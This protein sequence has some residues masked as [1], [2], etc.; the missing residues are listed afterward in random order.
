MKKLII[1][2]VVLCALLLS[3]SCNSVPTTTQST[4]TITTTHEEPATT[5]IQPTPQPVGKLRVHF[6]DVGQGDAILVDYGDTEIL[7]D[8]GD[9]SPGVVTYLS[10]FVDGAIEVMVATHPHADHIGG[11]IAVLEQYEVEV[12]IPAEIRQCDRAK[13]TP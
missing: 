6:I 7:I 4:Q 10:D 9:R 12:N 11:L 1:F 13:P 2:I 5:T 3:T 8:G